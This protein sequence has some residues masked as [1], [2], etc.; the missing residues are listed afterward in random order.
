MYQNNIY[1]QYFL[2][3]TGTIGF[4][5]QDKDSL[6]NRLFFKGV[7]ISLGGDSETNTSDFQDK[8][9]ILEK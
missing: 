6:A 1:V 9:V 3:L 5:S 8:K 2:V 7:S 4:C